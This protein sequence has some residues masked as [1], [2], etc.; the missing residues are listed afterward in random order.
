MVSLTGEISSDEFHSGSVLFVLSNGSS[1]ALAIRFDPVADS[2][3]RRE[4]QPGVNV[5]G[6][7]CIAESWWN[8]I[9]ELM[10]LS[11]LVMEALLGR[12]MS[13]HAFDR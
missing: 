8:S 7:V 3:G 2:N 5:L 4:K 1:D 6:E 13:S 12:R 9:G 11:C 10:E